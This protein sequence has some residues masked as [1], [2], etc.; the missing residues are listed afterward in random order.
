MC[1]D[2]VSGTETSGSF[3]FQNEKLV[4]EHVILYLCLDLTYKD[5]FI[6]AELTHQKDLKLKN[7]KY[8]K[9]VPYDAP[10]NKTRFN[11]LKEL[12]LEPLESQKLNYLIPL[13]YDLE[14]I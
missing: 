13:L 3:I 4:S 10:F 1:S 6:I 11:C 9:V 7:K 5:D 2:K 8:Y 12:E 14:S